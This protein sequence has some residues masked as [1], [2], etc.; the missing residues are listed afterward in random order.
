MSGWGAM[1]TPSGVAEIF[2][3]VGLS[4]AAAGV[5]GAMFVEMVQVLQRRLDVP[6]LVNA[7]PWWARWSLYYA[8]M[9]SLYFLYANEGQ[10]IYFQF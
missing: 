7:Q 4:V 3:G 9:A 2:R 5:A 1:R 6:A 8:G 10:F